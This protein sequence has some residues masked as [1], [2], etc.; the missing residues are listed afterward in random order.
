[1]VRDPH[2]NSWRQFTELVVGGK[3][4]H[5]SRFDNLL[6]RELFAEAKLQDNDFWFYYLGGTYQRPFVDDREMLDG[7]P[8]ERQAG[9]LGSSFFETDS[10]KPLQLQMGFSL[11]RSFPRFE[12][13]NQFDVT[14]VF[15]PLPQLEGSFNVSYNENAGT[16][17]QIRPAGALSASACA[18]LPLSCGGDPTVQLDPRA[19]VGGFRE[20]L[21]AQQQARSI[22]ALLRATYAF[23]PRLT[24]QAYAQ[25]FT[26]GISYGA[27]ARALAGAGKPTLRTADFT[28]ASADDRAPNANDRQAGL[29]VNLILRWE[30]RTGSTFYLVYAH[31]SSNDLT[32]AAG[33]LSF[34][35]ELSTLGA[36][37][38]THGDTLLVKVDL[39]AAI[40]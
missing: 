9:L 18:Q 7:T 22:S 37:G 23:T 15:R 19:A 16:W 27:P 30:W 24:L 33:P 13:V 31:Q 3:E 26:A 2:A 14:T 17:R 25:L 39:L 8:I 21:V 11:S 1:M 4:V 29:N 28:A 12:R 10:R 34:R 32:P 6:D 20:Y 40:Q 36:S 5:D 38:V 35:G